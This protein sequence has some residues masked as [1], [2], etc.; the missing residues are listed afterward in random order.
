MVYVFDNLISRM[1]YHSEVACSLC[2]AVLGYYWQE[3]V[4]VV[5]NAI[6]VSVAN[7]AR[8]YVGREKSKVGVENV[9]PSTI[10]SNSTKKA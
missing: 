5:Q 1:A 4:G 9:Q 10:H 6:F 2:G 7:T 8:W 3:H